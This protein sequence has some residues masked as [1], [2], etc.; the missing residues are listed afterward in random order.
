LAVGLA[1]SAARLSD[2][3]E[4]LRALRT[5]LD[6]AVQWMTG[7]VGGLSR[8]VGVLESQPMTGG[9]VARPVE[10]TSALAARGP[11]AAPTATDQ[12]RALESLA[13]RIHDPQ[14]QVAVAAELIRL[15]HQGE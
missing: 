4:G 10:K 1:D 13:G 14:A 5:T 2:I 12:Y 7:E 15:R 9:P 11:L 3:G 6:E 8:R